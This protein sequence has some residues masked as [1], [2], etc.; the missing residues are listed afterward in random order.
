VTRVQWQSLGVKTKRTTGK[1]ISICAS[2]ASQCVNSTQSCLLTCETPAWFSIHGPAAAAE[3]GDRNDVDIKHVATIRLVY[4]RRYHSAV[5]KNR[6]QGACSSHRI[7]EAEQRS[8]S[9]RS[10]PPTS[11]VETMCGRAM[12]AALFGRLIVCS[13]RRDSVKAYLLYTAFGTRVKNNNKSN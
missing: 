3:S 5:N 8:T 4:F 13:R 10:R 2:A 6:D 7:D 1:S 11:N 9:R 12:C